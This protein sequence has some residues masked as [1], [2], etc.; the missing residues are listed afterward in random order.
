MTIVHWGCEN[1]DQPPP[2]THNLCEFVT[3]GVHTCIS[4]RS[5][6]GSREVD[7]VCYLPSPMLSA[8]FRDNR[9]LLEVNGLYY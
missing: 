4:H 5:I 9:V 8:G 3:T 6:A 7:H 2:A 1:E